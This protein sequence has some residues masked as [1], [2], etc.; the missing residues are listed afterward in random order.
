MAFRG[1]CIWTLHIYTHTHTHAFKP[2]F[3]HPSTFFI[4]SKFIRYSLENG[5]K[6]WQELR[7]IKSVDISLGLAILLLDCMSHKW[8]RLNSCQLLHLSTQWDNTNLG[9][10]VTKQCLIL[11]SLWCKKVALAKTKKQKK[12]Q[13]K[14]SE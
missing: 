5:N 11:F 4:F 2:E 13:V 3:I 12:G 6:I 14:V 7:V 8:I 10:P 9:Q 1:F